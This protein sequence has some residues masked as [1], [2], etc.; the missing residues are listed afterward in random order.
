MQVLTF[1]LEYSIFSVYNIM[2]QK[3]RAQAVSRRGFPPRRLGFDRGLGYVGFIVNKMVLGQ[4]FSKYYGLPCQFSSHQMLHTHLSS[5]AGIKG[6]V[7]AD[8]QSGI[9]LTPSPQNK[10]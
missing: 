2:L 10:N 5:G 4:V 8:V 3:G 7:V 1:K 6:Q 9:T